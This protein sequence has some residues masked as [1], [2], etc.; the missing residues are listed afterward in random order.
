MGRAFGPGGRFAVVLWAAGKPGGRFAVVVEAVLTTLRRGG[1]AAWR[2]VMRRPVRR[3][4]T[5]VYGDGALKAEKSGIFNRF[6]ESS[7][8]P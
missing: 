2:G 8:F 4:L 1:D 3:S 7:E 6:E 5:T